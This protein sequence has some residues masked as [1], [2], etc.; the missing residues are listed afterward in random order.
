MKHQVAAVLLAVA[1]LL[2][3]NGCSAASTASKIDAAEDRVEEKLDTVEDSVE[4]A[5]QKAVTPAPASPEQAP[6]GITPEEA[7]K[8]ALDHV[9]VTADQ[10][11]GLR[12][13][14]EIDDRIPQY[15]IEFHSG[16]WEYEFEISAKDGKILSFDKDHIYD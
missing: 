1:L 14:Y 12:S 4:R 3:M 11:R 9:G 16:E 6:A 2:T 5:V 13:Q 10:V 8:I 15:D 7:E